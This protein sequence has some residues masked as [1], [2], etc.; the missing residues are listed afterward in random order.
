MNVFCN[1]GGF[2]GI[3]EEGDL[4]FLEGDWSKMREPPPNW[5]S[6]DNYALQ[7]FYM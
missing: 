6:I 4:C 5:G 1:E 3:S 2:V 7:S